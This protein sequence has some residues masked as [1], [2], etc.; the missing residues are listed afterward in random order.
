MN[1]SFKFNN[2]LYKVNFEDEDE[3]IVVEVE[4]NS[5]PVDYK[6]L[7]DNLYSVIIDG[8]SHQIA[9]LKK[10]KHIQVFFQG[11]LYNFES[12]SEREQKHGGLAA[13]GANQ[14]LSPM[15]SRIV[16][17]LKA[18]D[19]KVEENDGI[20]VVEAMKMESELKSPITGKI[21]EI[22]VKEGDTVEGGAVLALISDE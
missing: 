18:V 8:I 9:I 19:D 11:D 7:D 5:I 1:C 10:G 16:K 22:K 3:E 14:I 21:K 20:I 13:S 2:K 17:I 4:G 6:K 15:P 12:V